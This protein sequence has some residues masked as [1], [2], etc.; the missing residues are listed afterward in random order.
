MPE[1][2]ASPGGGPVPT[3][4]EREAARAWVREMAIEHSTEV[5]GSMLLEVERAFQAEARRVFEGLQERAS[6]P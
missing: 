1:A 3:V 4:D 5:A 6:A 2:E